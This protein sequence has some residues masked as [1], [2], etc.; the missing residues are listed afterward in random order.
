MGNAPEWNTVYTVHGSV[1]RRLRAWRVVA[2][3][4]IV[5]V[6]LSVVAGLWNLVR[7]PHPAAVALTA[8]RECRL[9]D[10]S[11]DPRIYLV[12]DVATNG[13]SAYP[14]GRS[15]LD[16]WPGEVLELGLAKSVPPLDEIGDDEFEDLA[17]NSYESLGDY[18]EEDIEHGVLVAV[19]DPK[20]AFG[21][22]EALDTVWSSGEPLYNQLIPVGLTFDRDSC[23]VADLP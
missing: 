7:T 21:V 13:P 9:S 15:S 6:S 8:P 22:V 17:A 23:T 19:I 14:S 20:P 11:T 3:V 12:I 1:L 2:I 10:D 16:G 18:W 4:G 5:V